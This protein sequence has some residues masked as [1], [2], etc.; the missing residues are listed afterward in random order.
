MRAAVRFLSLAGFLLL[1]GAAASQPPPPPITRP[2]PPLMP[3]PV[4]PG[5]SNIDHNGIV[6]FRDRNF[7]GPAVNIGQDEPNLRLS[8]RVGS[9]RVDR[10][11]WQLCERPN[12]QG[13]CITL[14][15]SS[16]NLG[17][18]T[19]QSVRA[20]VP[21]QAGWRA[22]GSADFNRGGRDRRVIDVRGNPRLASVRLCGENFA[23]RLHGARARFTNNASQA[24]HL[25]GSVE[26]GACTQPL[27]LGGPR[28]NLLAVEVTATSLGTGRA[29]IRLEG[30]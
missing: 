13:S 8:W 16:S 7:D 27:S 19:V 2:A 4:Q 23:L 6:I 15:Q 3:I 22:L 28:R 11:S 29:R 9:A 25:P 26:R 5:N 14:S 30:R 21:A 17:S 20:N 10:G 1:A 24:L 18:K 12:Y